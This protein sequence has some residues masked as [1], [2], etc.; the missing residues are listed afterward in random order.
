MVQ[1]AVGSNLWT[2]VVWRRLRILNG[3]GNIRTHKIK[4]RHGAAQQH[5]GLAI[6]GATELIMD[7]STVFRGN[8]ASAEE[9]GLFTQRLVDN[10]A[11]K[12]HQIKM[13]D[14]IFEANS[15]SVGGGFAFSELGK[16]PSLSVLQTEFTDNSASDS[17]GLGPF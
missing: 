10:T 7:S 1:R 6:D 12:G 2:K 4:I 11:D 5:D 3:S 17:G 13:E 15:A 9:V 16:L 14:S 8:T